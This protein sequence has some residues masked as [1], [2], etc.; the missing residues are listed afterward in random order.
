MITKRLFG[1]YNGT[2]IYAYTLSGGIRAEICTLGATV[3]SLCVPNLRGEFVDVAL[4]MLTPSD[5]V[6]KGDYMGSVVGRCCNRIENGKFT[7]NGKEYTLD[8]NNGGMHLHGGKQGFSFQNFSAKTEGDKLILSYFSPDGQGGYPGNLSFSV[9]YSV[10]GCDFNVDYFAECDQDTV[11]SPT[12][13]MY[14]NLNGQSDGS[15][16]DNVLQIFADE[17]CAVDGRLIP[18][19]VEKVQ[20]TPFDFRTE[21][22]IGR[23]LS[24]ENEQL[25]LAGGYDHNFCLSGSVA[26]AN[27]RSPKTGITMQ[28]ITDRPGIQFYGG[29]FLQGQVGKATYNRRS[30]FCLETQTYP[31]AINRADFA[32]PVLKKGQKF[33]S[34]TTYRFGV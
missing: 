5:V 8:T 9:V 1:K 20:G 27:V 31:N 32:S 26:A 16:A 4:G 23:D 19:V 33:H 24:A 25:T 6:E 17:Y 13:H 15:I 7:L 12:N 30:G 29:N 10:D 22:T 2:D 34:R 28:V 11:F 14:F 21:K 18:T 3:L